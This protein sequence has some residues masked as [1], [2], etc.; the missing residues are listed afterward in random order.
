MPLIPVA[1]P[2]ISVLTAAVVSACAVAVVLDELEELIPASCI[3]SEILSPAVDIVDEMSD[4]WELI[5]PITM[6]LMRI[7]NARKERTMIAAAP[8]LPT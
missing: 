5:P 8:A 1:I 6:R 7:A 4:D 2:V 3:Q